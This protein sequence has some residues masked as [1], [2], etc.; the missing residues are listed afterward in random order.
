MFF[1]SENPADKISVHC[2]LRW[3]R[4][5]DLTK[6]LFRRMC[7]EVLIFG[8]EYFYYPSTYRHQ[9]LI[10]EFFLNRA[11]RNVYFY[12]LPIYCFRDRAI[13]IEKCSKKTKFPNLANTPPPPPPPLKTTTFFEIL[14][15]RGS[16]RN[17]ENI[18]DIP[19]INS[20]IILVWVSLFKTFVKNRNN[21]SFKFLNYRRISQMK[22]QPER[23]GKME[24]LETLTLYISQNWATRF[25]QLFYAN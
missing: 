20:I 2:P 22:Y 23:V 16:D 1:G 8:A 25:G 24:D 7:R 9:I 18:Y 15:N 17:K 14:N 21:I 5:S 6:A 19:R 4:S 11:F 3:W 12:R 10:F 13:W